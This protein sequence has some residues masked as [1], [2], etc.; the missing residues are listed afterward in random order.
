M[1][2]H[3]IPEPGVL[4]E[5]I[6]SEVTKRAQSASF[7][8]LYV[9]RSNSSLSEVAELAANTEELRVVSITPFTEL[10][11]VLVFLFLVE[12][13]GVLQLAKVHCP[14]LHLA[15]DV[16]SCVGAV[17]PVQV[18]LF[19][20]GDIRLDG[21]PGHII[22]MALDTDLLVLSTNHNCLILKDVFTPPILVSDELVYTPEETVDVRLVSYFSIGIALYTDS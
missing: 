2:R 13:L 3:E 19:L 11:R 22:S 20:L 7:N 1:T 17:V 5:I 15:L 18:E 6:H 4:D 9:R 8:I 10:V 16:G 14:L 21:V 12:N